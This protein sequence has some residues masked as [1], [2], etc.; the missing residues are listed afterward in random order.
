MLTISFNVAMSE[1][2]EGL[3]LS[4]WGECWLG[5]TPQNDGLLCCL[6]LYLLYMSGYI[7]GQAT[8]VGMSFEKEQPEDV[9]DSFSYLMLG[10]GAVQKVCS[11]SSLNL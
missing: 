7:L 10:N 6:T 9:F 2:K 11:R 8:Q 3:L 5:W 1:T 4:I